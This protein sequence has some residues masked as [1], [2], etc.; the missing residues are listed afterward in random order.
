M[1]EAGKEKGKKASRTGSI[2]RRINRRSLSTL[3]DVFVLSDLLLLGFYV[4]PAIGP[5]ASAG[6]LFRRMWELVC[7]R[8]L[9]T[10]F[11]LIAGLQGLTLFLQM[12]FGAASVRRQLR[13]LDRLVEAAQSVKAFDEST[14]HM[15][16][17]AIGDISPTAED[18]FLQLGDEE[19]K[20][21]EKAVNELIDRMRASYRQQARFVSDASHELRTPIA[22]IRGYADMLDRWGKTD[23]TVLN[24]SIAAIRS[25]SGHMQ[26]LVEQL[27]FLARGDS[28]RTQLRP[29]SLDLAA[30]MQETREE[31]AMIDEKH[32]YLFEAA[33]PVPAWGDVSLLK[34]TARILIDN[35]AKYTPAGGEIVLRALRYEGCPAFSVQ[36]SGIGISGEA[37]PHVFERFYRADSSRARETGGTGLG[38]AIAKWI[39][40]RHGG[41]FVLTSREEIG[42]RILVRLPKPPETPPAGAPR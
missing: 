19:L 23:E 11:L 3:F 12:L 9:K 27:L 14:F 7:E 35:A 21:L 31:S 41:R 37:L 15:L 28:G 4:F 33:G 42:T 22:V 17:E 26:H 5:V 30:M 38:L 2:A 32:T 36:D 25:E 10:D 8:V 6:E 16:E 13:P 40:D 39:V 24:E 1:P 29:E 20:P 18:A 34:Q